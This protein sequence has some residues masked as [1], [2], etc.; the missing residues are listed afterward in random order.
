MRIFIHKSNS[1]LR[2]N[3]HFL[4]LTYIKV[5]H[6]MGIKGLEYI[7]ETRRNNVNSYI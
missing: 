2:N 1:K 4:E 3:L 6:F 7:N 5:K